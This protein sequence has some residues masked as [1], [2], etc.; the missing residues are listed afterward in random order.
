[1]LPVGGI[2]EKVLAAHRA[3]VKTVILPHHNEGALEDVPEE[4]RRGLQIIL[5]ESVDEVLSAALPAPVDTRGDAKP[6][7]PAPMH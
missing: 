4:V 5:V 3:G 1:V 7:L 6:E 2:K